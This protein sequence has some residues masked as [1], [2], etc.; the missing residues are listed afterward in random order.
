MDNTAGHDSARYVR[1]AGR[2]MRAHVLHGTSTPQRVVDKGS[3]SR[4][5]PTV[6]THHLR[7]LAGPQSIC[8]RLSMQAAA[9]HLVVVS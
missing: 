9:L 1:S 8:L 3:D 5:I 4:V 6:R 7:T 2:L